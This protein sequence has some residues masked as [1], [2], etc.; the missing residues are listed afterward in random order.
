MWKGCC[1]TSNF[2]F[3]WS[4]H[5]KW[6]R[7]VVF[8]P[9]SE[10]FQSRN[11]FPLQKL[12][13]GSFLYT[14]GSHGEKVAPSAKIS[15]YQ[16]Q[17]QEIQIWDLSASSRK[18]NK[19]FK[20]WHEVI[21]SLKLCQLHFFYTISTE[22]LSL[23]FVFKGWL[24]LGTTLPGLLTSHTALSHPHAPTHRTYLCTYSH[25]R[26]EAVRWGVNLPL[27]FCVLHFVLMY[28]L[29]LFT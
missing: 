20:T 1:S 2:S 28:A 8:P 6:T 11:L 7:L 23:Q 19:M 27:Q 25:T 10:C 18:K 3:L 14:L 21:L 5:L 13:A 16:S 4:V 12:C 15:S 17:Q 29:H 26:R 22:P 24:T 9:V